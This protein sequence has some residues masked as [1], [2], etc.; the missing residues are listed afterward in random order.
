MKAGYAYKCGVAVDQWRNTTDD[1]WEIMM[2][3]RPG[4]VT[5]Q[6]FRT[7]DGVSCTVW[8]RKGEIYAQTATTAKPP[9]GMR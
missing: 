2:L 8:L 9:K 4:K 5:F 6:G 1:D 3:A 7:I